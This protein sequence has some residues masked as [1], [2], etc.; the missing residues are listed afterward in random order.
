MAP[1][2]VYVPV[3]QYYISYTYKLNIRT[4]NVF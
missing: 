2:I 3:F 4:N 1:S